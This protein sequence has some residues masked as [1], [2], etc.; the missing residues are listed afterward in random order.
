MESLHCPA[1]M[2]HN[3]CFG[4]HGL[5]K[6]TPEQAFVPDTTMQ[7]AGGPP[8]GV[9]PPPPFVSGVLAHVMAQAP[10]YKPEELS[11]TLFLLALWGARVGGNGAAAAATGPGEGAGAGAP[12]ASSSSSSSGSGT[13]SGNGSLAGTPGSSGAQGGAGAVLAGADTLVRHIT[14]TCTQYDGPSLCVTAWALHQLTGAS[15]S[16]SSSSQPSPSTPTSPTEPNSNPSPSALTPTAL[17][18]FESHLLSLFSSAPAPTMPFP[19]HHLFRFLSTCASASYTPSA[20]LPVY[21]V[22]ALATLQQAKPC[23]RGTP[24]ALRRSKILWAVARTMS[25]FDLRNPKLIAAL[26]GAAIS[27]SGLLQPPHLMGI[28][29]SLAELGHYP[30][31]WMSKGL[32]KAVG[33]ALRSASFTH[34]S[35]LLQALAAW[36]G[37]LLAVAESAPEV[38]KREREE[39]ERKKAQ[40]A[41][42]ETQGPGEE[43]QGQGQEQGQSEQQEGKEGKHGQREEKQEW[44]LHPLHVAQLKHVVLERL[45]ALLEVESDPQRLTP[46]Q[47]QL[48]QQSR[49]PVQGP[50][51][52][53]APEPSNTATG[54]PP[55]A[56]AS[57]QAGAA[58][59][60]TALS[61]P[62]NDVMRALVSLAR[63]R[64]RH[65]GVEAVL[66]RGAARVAA[67]RRHSVADVCSVMWCLA[68]L[69]HDAPD[70]MD[71]LQ[72]GGYCWVLRWGG[73]DLTVMHA[74]R[75]A[76][77]GWAGWAS[78][79]P[80]VESPAVG[81]AT[82][83]P[84]PVGPR[85]QGQ[86][87]RHTNA[88]ARRCVV[89]LQA[90]LMGLPQP[91]PLGEEM[92]LLE[93]GRAG[94][95]A[96]SAGPEAA[97]SAPGASAAATGPVHQQ[98]QPQPPAASEGTSTPEAAMVDGEPQQPQLQRL[99]AE[100]ATDARP[101][102]SP[103]AEAALRAPASQA[104]ATPP[105]RPT[106]LTTAPSG[107]LLSR[108][109]L[110]PTPSPTASADGVP[111]DSDT[112]PATAP[113]PAPAAT[114]FDP[115]AA[116]AAAAA[117]AR[118]RYERQQATHG[119]PLPSEPWTAS[120]V[121]KALWSC[122]KM[123][124][125][126]GPH[127]LAAAERSW[128]LHTIQREDNAPVPADGTAGA[129]PQLQKPPLHALTGLLWALATFRQHNGSFADL[130]ATQLA[131]RLAAD[132]DAL[133][134]PSMPHLQRQ[135]PQVHPV[136]S[137]QLA[138]CL[139]AAQADR[140]DCPLAHALG[141][142]GRARC[143]A[144]WRSGTAAR[145]AQPPNRYQAD[146][147][148]VLRKMGFAAAANVA[149]PD[150]CTLVDVAVALPPPPAAAAAVQPGQP[151]AAPPA[152]RLLA[153]ELVGRHNSAVNSPRITGEAV[154]KYR[155]LQVSDRGDA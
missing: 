36:G 21:T 103:V 20:L 62:L 58:A 140:S 49:L 137:M 67:E 83:C 57:S 50:P 48:L 84:L 29:S 144:A 28:L 72:V 135:L 52:A 99:A 2:H 76:G 91:R 142:E 105:P 109:Q 104:S 14:A 47:Q 71:D 85:R 81:P 23:P 37:E 146:M 120:D 129:T 115:A 150:G 106:A 15:P 153:L 124:R 148:A 73:R 94:T 149:T 53:A 39:A 19:D 16:S 118:E 74:L 131:D 42:G 18:A 32:L 59:E 88:H 61:L 64:W 116:T 24:A 51:P 154:L 56:A 12:D 152:P 60:L 45:A 75:W 35:L 139:L 113:P 87:C 6:H 79:S 128:R 22:R 1:C 10:A 17:A 107:S 130:L 145:A 117:A 31:A 134:T 30:R 68:V 98:R 147:L 41:H 138:S 110:P 127:I 82:V 40:Q 7:P 25:L 90:A 44:Q 100:A 3:I 26:E 33:Y 92:A 102:A 143:I 151:P 63:L 121:F 95:T 9:R 69:R 8:A 97:A 112:S 38:Q 80:W 122:A 78:T 126:P 66:L 111:I 114:P 13:G 46:W 34:V 5:Q 119:S 89:P 27:C 96:S 132:P 77:L 11:T 141:P 4:R 125:H 43:E 123:N 86:L 101:A 65:L 55:Q 93:S 70:L 136:R 54:E 133:S 108:P 155:L